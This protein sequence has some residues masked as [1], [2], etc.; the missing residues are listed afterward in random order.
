MGVN[1]TDSISGRHWSPVGQISVA[2]L[3]DFHEK[4]RAHPSPTLYL[5]C[6]VTRIMT[7]PSPEER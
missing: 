2:R 4:A 6:R 7:R 1:A 3:V 5:S